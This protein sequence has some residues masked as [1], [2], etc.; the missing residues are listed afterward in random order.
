MRRSFVC[1][2]FYGQRADGQVKRAALLLSFSQHHGCFVGHGREMLGKVLGE[3]R[4]ST[5]KKQV[6]QSIAGAFP[7]NAVLYQWRIVQSAACALCGHPTEAQSHIQCSCP[8]LRKLGYGPTTTWHRHCGKASSAPL[9]SG[10][11]LSSKQCRVSWAWHSRKSTLT[12]G[13]GHGTKF[14]TLT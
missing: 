12:Y 4:I 8:A 5:A 11:L 3:M 7:G 14:P 6:L 13:R 2:A 1:P 9:N 10:S